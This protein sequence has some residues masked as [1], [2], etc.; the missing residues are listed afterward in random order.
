MEG[1]LE[2]LRRT[3]L[4]TICRYLQPGMH[5]LEIGGGSGYQAS[6]M[7]SIG[8][9]VVSID[10]PS[11][12]V[13]DQCF[14]PVYVYDGRH[15]PI[16]SGS[17]DIVFSSNVLEHV[18]QLP[19]L[20]REIHRVLKPDGLAI[21]ILPSASWRLWTSLAHYGFVV[22]FL[23]RFLHAQPES[24][25]A[26][27]EVQIGSALQRHGL[28]KIIMWGVVNP[29]RPHGEY[30][31][32]LAELYYFSKYR[33]INTFRHNGFQLQKVA[34]NSLFYTGYGLFPNLPMRMRQRMALVLGSSCHIFVMRPAS[35]LSTA[36]A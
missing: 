12:P 27:E 33:W 14:Y 34:E 26:S 15:I 22:K 24:E 3:E 36:S 1:L 5:I 6:R 7:A 18:P 32:A 25:G 10:L 17:C 30:P 13:P 31:N 23:L 9:D 19:L 8:C 4:D 28:R 21:H 35:S 29:I 16:A 20:F 11:R 2:K